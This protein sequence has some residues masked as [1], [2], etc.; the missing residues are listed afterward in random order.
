MPIISVIIPVYNAEKYLHRCIDSILAQ[1]FTDLEL[2]LI[3]DGS[4]DKS[5]A[6]CDEYAQNDSRVRVFH[7]KNGG[8]SSARNLGLENACGEW[9]SFIDSDDWIELTMYEKLYGKAIIENADIVYS[10]MMMVFGNN[11][12]CYFTANYTS[13]KIELMK[14]YISSVWT[15]LVYMIVKRN[16]YEDNNLKSPTYLC[17]CE[18]FW[19]SVRLFHFAKKISYVN[20]AFYNYNRTNELSAMHD[21]TKNTEKDEQTAYLETI[22]FFSKQ[23]F[24]SHYEKEMSWRILKSKQELILNSNRHKEFL[25][26]YPISH[27]YLWSCPY[28]NKKIKLMIWLLIKKLYWLLNL[29]IIFRKILRKK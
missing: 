3:N 11:K 15:C 28:I 27:K 18:D 7:K 26:I 8:V 9:I 19:L 4:S 5:G 13:D 16:I 29:I 24:I 2:L 23:G 17:Y 22:D 1:T 21:I 20:E 6:I 10:N 12:E 25:E 14:N